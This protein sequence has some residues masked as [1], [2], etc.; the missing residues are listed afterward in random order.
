MST[1][2]Y[3]QHLRRLAWPGAAGARLAGQLLEAEGG[4][5]E[6][7]AAH[8]D[9]QGL[10]CCVQRVA[11][12]AHTQLVSHGVYGGHLCPGADGAESAASSPH[13]A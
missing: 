9:V 6:V 12:C 7:E 8:G 1:Q 11:L 5:A 3:F 13:S 2:A 4:A 10:V